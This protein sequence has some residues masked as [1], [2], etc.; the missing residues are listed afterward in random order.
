MTAEDA[1]E[2]LQRATQ[3]ALE[4]DIEGAISAL[5][6]LVEASPDHHA[7]WL[8][9]GMVFSSADRWD[10]ASRALTRAVELAGDVAQARLALARALEKCGQLEGA[11]AE[12]RKAQAQSPDDVRPLKELG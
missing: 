8:H 10:E 7:A 3:R 1:F 12:L 6:A 11:V 9:L 4:G 5:L 2:P